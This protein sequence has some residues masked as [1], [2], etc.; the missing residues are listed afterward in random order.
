MG[1]N[2]HFDETKQQHSFFS[3]KEKAWHQLGI[4][5]EDYPTSAEAIKFAGLDYEVEKMP[6]VLR[7]ADGTER[8]SKNSFFTYRKDTGIALGEF[9]GKDYTVVQNLDA[10]RFFDSIVGG[11]GGILFETAGALGN[12][13]IIFIT[14]KL[15]G[16]IKVGKDDLAEQ[17]LFL[18]NSFD[19]KTSLQ[20]GFTPVRVVCNNTLNAALTGNPNK[21]KIYHT[22]RVEHD[23]EE[24]KKVLGL[25]NRMPAL[26]EQCFNRMAVIKITDKQVKK[27]IAMAMAPTKELYNQLVDTD[28]FEQ[29]EISTRFENVTADVF[30]YYQGA[31]EQQLE[32]TKGTLYGAY[33]AITG[34]YQNIK[35]FGRENDRAIEKGSKKLKNLL[36]GRAA[37]NGQRALK[38]C[39][40]IMKSSAKL[41]L[42]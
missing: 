17:Y 33:N 11:Q 4:I 32:S 22:G 28:D 20:V 9:L 40:D 24:A 26:Y 31:P 7:L 34:Y 8:T 14:A 10:F 35:E 5:V 41:V 23:L 36:F 15:P 3:V 21:V 12:G 19:G 25:V 29:A 13:E 16:Y 30:D 38:L 27:L 6:N 42:N 1:H 2:L 39:E 18:T 37:N